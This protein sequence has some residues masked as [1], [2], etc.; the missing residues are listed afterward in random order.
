VLAGLLALPCACLAAAEAP[1]RRHTPAMGLIPYP[2]TRALVSVFDP[3]RG[4]LH[5]ALGLRVVAYTA[6]SHVAFVDARRALRQR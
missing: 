2:S 3:L 4:H 5:T 6:V 1:A